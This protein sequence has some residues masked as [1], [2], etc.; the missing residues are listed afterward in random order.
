MKNIA[1]L[2]LI[3][4][5]FAVNLYAQNYNDA[6]LAQ[7]IAKDSTNRSSN[8]ALHTLTVGEHLYR[9]DV[10]MAN[11]QFP[12]AREHWQKVIAVYPSNG[13]MPRALFGMGRSNMWERKYETAV[14]WFDRLFKNYPTTQLGQ[15]GLAYKG[16]SYVRLSKNLE[17]AN[18]YEQYTVMFPYGKRIA[19]SF[20]NIIDAYREA[21][22]YDKANL[23]VNKTRKRF[24]GMAVETN[25]L[26]ARL[27]ME[28]Y[29]QNW[30]GAISAADQLLRLRNFSGSMAF[31]YEV[32]YLKAMA[33]EKSG[34][35]GRALSTY[36]SIPVSP[37]S[38]FGG[39]ATE[40]I[41]MLGGNARYRKASMRT[42]S[43]RIA[44][45]YPVMFRNELLR[46]SKSRG[47]DPRFVL[48]IMKQ[49]SSFRTRAKSPA[50]ARGLLQLTFDTALKYNKQA[51]FYNIK[52]TDLYRSNVNIAIGSVY[53][54]KLKN[55]F[56]GLYEGIAASYNAG[57]DNAARWLA[58]SKPKDRAIFASE[59]GFSETKRYVFKVMSN[60]RVYQELYTENL[61]R[62]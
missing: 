41:S 23:W 40:R 36:S 37:T 28:V 9:A 34:Q 27:R 18:A 49:E 58:R 53:I 60:Y 55:E 29:R 43:R 26:H 2:T 56:G 20:L 33:F 45:K 6:T 10:Y 25:A 16:A 47:I 61:L 38:Y 52:G 13:N 31:E 7:V 44:R 15:D 19:S 48:A 3:A 12:Q 62:K 4:L 32:S 42:Q 30:R 39:L 59:V 50:A 51:G 24:N 21:G 17:A 46:Y 11:R 57:E 14:V 22:K 1:T 8:G 35:K 5:L 54:A